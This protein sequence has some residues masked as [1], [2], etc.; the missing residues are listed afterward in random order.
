M[1]QGTA[2]YPGLF[3]INRGT[4]SR[5]L[6]IT[7]AVFSFSIAPQPELPKETGTLTLF[8]G[9]QKVELKDCK[10]DQVAFSTDGA[11]ILTV[12]I[13]DF[14]WKWSFG[15]ISGHYNIRNPDGTIRGFLNVNDRR[16]VVNSERTPQELATLLLEAMG[17]VSFDVGDLPNDARPTVEWEGENPAAM[18]AD[19]CE[20]LG[21]FIVPGLDN[22][23]SIRQQNTGGQLPNIG[24]VHRRDQS[25]DP[26]EMPDE[27]RIWCGETYYQADVALEAVAEDVD[28]SLKLLNDVSYKPL[29]GWTITDVPEFNDVAPEAKNLAKKSVFRYYRVKV[30]ALIPGFGLVEKLDQLLPLTDVQ[31]DS[32]TNNGIKDPKPAIV[33]G[34][35]TAEGGDSVNQADELLPVQDDQDETVIRDFSLD[36]ERGLV[37]MGD[38]VYKLIGEVPD[39]TIGPAELVLRAAFTV[40]SPE[41]MAYVR[42][43]KALPNRGRRFGTGHR[44]IKK[45]DLRLTHRCDYI[46][47]DDGVFRVG[48]ITTNQKEVDEEADY[49]LTHEARAYETQL[50]ET[51]VYS[52]IY[53]IELDG[54]I[55]RVSYN[56]GSP[57][58]STTVERG[59]DPGGRQAVP[60]RLV[61][62]M[63]KMKA[64]KD[65]QKKLE[66]RRLRDRAKRAGGK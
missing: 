50:A 16:A 19:L 27:L 31:V 55:M 46:R 38:F 12:S 28:S 34:V 32:T 13:L 62:A 21:C 61:R 30:P 66:P 41:T 35:W 65:L 45:E 23:V 58:A 20:Q 43:E 40:R 53:P 54:T 18:L 60:Y 37:M 1:L 17:V 42:Y 10:V 56:I 5:G 11:N 4:V 63:E 29:G 57:F 44:L 36:R 9:R 64:A 22:S 24:H 52:G 33:F 15:S 48:E 59:R 8:Y 14:R 25:I 3:K 26:A 39:I 49:Y 47:G 2:T 6:G 51:I 7:P